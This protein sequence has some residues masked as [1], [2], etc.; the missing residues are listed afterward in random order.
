MFKLAVFY[1]ISKSKVL[2]IARDPC[3]LLGKCSG[4]QIASINN[5]RHFYYIQA[6]QA[7]RNKIRSQMYSAI[8]GS[9]LGRDIRAGDWPWRKSVRYK[10][11]QLYNI[12][13][14]TLVN[15]QNHAWLQEY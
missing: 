13:R 14:A 2:A 1:Y 15:G 12:I 6:L 8:Q 7:F 11:Y 4:K 5:M 3:D 10:L 9:L